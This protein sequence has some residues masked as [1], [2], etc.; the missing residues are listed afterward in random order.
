M[1]RDSVRIGHPPLSIRTPVGMAGV[2]SLWE[3]VRLD[4][5]SEGERQ[6]VGLPRKR[7]VVHTKPCI[8]WVPDQINHVTSFLPPVANKPER[9]PND[10]G[11]Q[12]WT[13]PLHAKKE[14]PHAPPRFP[15]EPSS[16]ASCAL[17]ASACS[18]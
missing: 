1:H 10:G 5:H 3:L 4:V 16:C 9:N 18:G 8:Q 14:G 7:L 11:N 17:L 2:L 15:P 6:A 13:H 12:S